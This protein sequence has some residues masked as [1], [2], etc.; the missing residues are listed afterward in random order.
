MAQGKFVGY[1]A[2]WTANDGFTPINIDPSGLTHILYAFANIG[3]DLRISL[4][5]PNLDPYNF[6]LLNLL[7]Q[8]NPGLKTLISVGGW[9][10]SGLFSEAALNE[11]SRTVFSESCSDFIRRYGFDGVDIDWEYPVSGGL[12]TNISR[13]EDRQNFTL[14]LRSLRETLNRIGSEDGNDYLLSIAGGVGSFYPKNT[15]LS[16]I[17]PYLDFASIMSYDIHGTWDA[18]TDFNAPLYLNDD[19][20]PQY[21]WSVDSGV[22]EWSRAGFPLDKL[23]LGIPF[24]GYLYSSVNPDNNGLYQPYY[25]ANVISY[26]QVSSDYL[27]TPQ[28]VRF[29][30]PQSKVPWL[31]GNSIFISYDDPESIW[32]KAEYIKR[33][34]LQGAMVWEFSQDPAHVLQTALAGFLRDHA[35]HAYPAGNGIPGSG[36]SR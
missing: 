18:Y 4:G 23:L 33:N 3:P 11:E 21:Q 30:H 34:G 31:F 20:S 12:P 14:L 6:E 25:G 36:R 8:R 27:T 9:T 15:E 16:L 29:F 17:H 2:A 1:Y 24:Y 28:Y 10:W 32:Y 22:Q 13:P 19:I 5:Y 7:K 26:G 35:V